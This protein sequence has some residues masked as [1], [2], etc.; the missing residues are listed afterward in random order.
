MVEPSGCGT[1][2]T[3]AQAAGWCTSSRN[4]PPTD[5]ASRKPS[6]VLPGGGSEAWLL[7][8]DTCAV[9]AP[10]EAVVAGEAAA[11]QHDPAARMHQHASVLPRNE[12]AATWPCSV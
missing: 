8:A 6:P 5:W 4:R 7:P 12:R 3:G 11:G 2:E 9:N 10:L 1:S